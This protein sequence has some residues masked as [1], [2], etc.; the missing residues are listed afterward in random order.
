[1]TLSCKLCAVSC[2][3]FIFLLV[4]CSQNLNFTDTLLEP[5]LT[6]I[7]KLTLGPPRIRFG[8]AVAIDGDFTV[9][10]AAR[11]DG[12]QVPSIARQ[13]AAYIYQKDETGHWQLVK[14]LLASDGA[15]LD[16]F[17]TSVAISGN[18]VVVGAP[19]DIFLTIPASGS[20]YIFERDQGGA[21]NWGEVQKLVASNPTDDD[22]FD[23]FG[24]AV[25]IDKDVVVVGAPLDDIDT[26]LDQGS[27]YVFSRG[28]S[29][30]KAWVEVERLV[31]SDGVAFDSF[32]RTVAISRNTVVVGASLDS[33]GDDALQGAA[34]LFERD[35]GGPN[36]WG[37]LKK[38]LASDGTA[39]DN[40]SNSVAISRNTVVVGAPGKD[41][42]YIFERDK[43]SWGEVQK[44]VA[45]DGEA[46]DGFG[47]SVAISRKKVAVGAPLD[48]V[49][50]IIE[51]DLNQGSVYIFSY[52]R[53]GKSAWGQTEKLLASDRG[54]GDLLGNA[55]AIDG[56]TVVAG[57]ERHLEGNFGFDHGAAYIFTKHGAK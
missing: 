19:G 40:F 7:Q 22:F 12:P 9:I 31:A 57:A 25:A 42:A 1:M 11:K 6:E 29:S 44:L 53:G 56:K 55:V 41:A 35:R 10:G 50:P 26:N 24:S 4:A 15:E 17:G 48:D 30:N 36:N 18:R 43:G 5:Q 46:G 34:Y 8:N 3:V 51:D 45:S 20:A 49:L 2:S 37:E 32:G 13:G 52:N 21:N 28:R 54:S 14:E 23:F 33:S 38:L 27:A 39:G 16:F 47:S